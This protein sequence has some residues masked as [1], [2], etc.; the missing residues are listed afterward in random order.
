MRN[1]QVLS[2]LIT[3]CIGDALGVPV[4]FS[5]RNQRRINPVTEMIGYGPHNQPPTT[6]QLV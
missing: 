2:G 6:R 1:S 3:V 4:E 5:S